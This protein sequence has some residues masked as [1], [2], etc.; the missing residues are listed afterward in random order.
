MIELTEHGDLPMPG[1]RQPTPLEL[2][3]AVKTIFGD[4]PGTPPAAVIGDPAWDGGI[5]FRARMRQLM[6]GGNQQF[7]DELL[8]V[9]I[10][11][12]QLM[13]QYED[14]NQ[15]VPAV[16]GARAALISLSPSAAKHKKLKAVFRLA[17]GRTRTIHFGDSRYDD[18][19]SHGTLSRKNDYIRRHEAR[20]DFNDPMTAGALSRWILWN[21]KTI[22]ASL[23]DYMKRFGL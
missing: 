19:T 15:A 14:Y 17:N 5:T 11:I 8:Q 22:K 9:T 10:W 3:T 23:A 4:I 1:I 2:E 6:P 13:P 20:E 12:E 7:Y 21:K 18:Y 16:G